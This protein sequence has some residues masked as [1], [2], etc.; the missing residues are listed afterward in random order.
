MI[1][2]APARSSLHWTRCAIITF[3]YTCSES[4]ALSPSPSPPLPSAGS[5]VSASLA[6]SW[7]VHEACRPRTI[8]AVGGV[9]T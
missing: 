8:W 1:A 3:A 7:A 9:R 4:A 2:R 6:P 5:A